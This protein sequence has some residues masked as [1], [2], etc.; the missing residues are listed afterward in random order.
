MAAGEIFKASL[1][2]SA[3]RGGNDVRAARQLSAQASLVYQRWD[4]AGGD[5][6]RYRKEKVEAWDV[7][8]V[9]GAQG[10][11]GGVCRCYGRDLSMRLCA[12][13]LARILVCSCSA[14]ISRGLWCC[15]SGPHSKNII[16]WSMPT[17]IM[18]C[19][20]VKWL[21]ERVNNWLL[22]VSFPEALVSVWS[23]SP[24]NLPLVQGKVR[25]LRGCC[26]S[27]LQQKTMEQ[28]YV[29]DTC[30]KILWKGLFFWFFLV[31][32]L[33][34]SLLPVFNSIQAGF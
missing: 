30:A 4:P 12:Q 27:I 26:F 18:L 5:K 34:I 22:A 13:C 19:N 33:L 31:L 11:E 2:E 23:L 10:G 6:S 7:G 25:C 28:H 16:A 9:A 29:L 8:E 15:T 20:G 14:V 21:G 24:S 1:P 3:Q 17:V 32:L